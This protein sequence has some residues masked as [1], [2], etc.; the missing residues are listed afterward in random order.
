MREDFGGTTAVLLRR[1]QCIRKKAFDDIY[2]IGLDKHGWE[3]EQLIS[4]VLSTRN[5]LDISL[6][7]LSESPLILP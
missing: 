7:R 1:V 4:E 3:T 5:G 2:E 6:E